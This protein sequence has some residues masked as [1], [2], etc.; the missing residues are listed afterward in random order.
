MKLYFIIAIFLKSLEI[1][2]KNL[3]IK[4]KFQK[5]DDYKYKSFNVNR[6]KIGYYKPRYLL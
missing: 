2:Q 1:F 5:F 6:T 3:Q 4:Q